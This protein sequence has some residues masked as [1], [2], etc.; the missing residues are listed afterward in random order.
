M[1]QPSSEALCLE[2][3]LERSALARPAASVFARAPALAR[4]AERFAGY[5]P[6]QV[7]SP[8]DARPLVDAAIEGAITAYFRD[9]HSDRAAAQAFIHALLARAA[10][11]SDFSLR[12]KEQRWNPLHESPAAWLARHPRSQI[13]YDGQESGALAPAFRAHL[14]ALLAGD[15][16]LTALA[17]TRAQALG[18]RD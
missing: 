3:S 1:T 14:L 12:H 18:F 7:G 2:Q 13:A 8:H 4:V 10:V 6:A 15:D 16:E 17:L 5:L 11:L 9:D